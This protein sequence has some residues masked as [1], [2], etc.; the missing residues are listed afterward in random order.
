[1]NDL[2]VRYIAARRRLFDRYYEGKLNEEQR[3]AVMTLNGPLLILA[4]AGSGKTTVLVNRIVFMIK[5]GNAY[6]NET[7]PDDIDEASVA[8]MEAAYFME[9]SPKK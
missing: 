3:R 9:G 8:D 2:K 5:Y 6:Y 4:G 7:V 1:M